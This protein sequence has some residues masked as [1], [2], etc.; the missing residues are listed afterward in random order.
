MKETKKTRI[1]LDGYAI[2]V[3]PLSWTLLK[4]RIMKE[5]KS[6]VPTK[7]AG[8]AYETE[9]GYF[10]SPGQLLRRIVQLDLSEAKD[11]YDIGVFINHYTAMLKERQDELLSKREELMEALE[12]NVASWEMGYDD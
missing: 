3:D 7:R 8:E 9:E 11:T 2:T 1:E 12:I 10:H 6:G 4:K 5:R